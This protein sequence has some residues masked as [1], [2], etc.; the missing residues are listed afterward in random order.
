MSVTIDSLDIQIRSSAGSASANIDRLADSLGKLREN[1][2]LSVVANNLT[3]LSE[4]LG[5][6]QGSSSGLSSIKGL[7]GAMKSLSQ[8]EKSSGLNSTL[9]SLK[10]LP[11]IVNQ[12]DVG[13]LG[14]FSAKMR[15]LAAA[16]APLSTQLDKVSRSF[17]K[18]PAR[19]SQIVTGTNRMAKASR[20]AAEAQEEHNEAIDATSLNLATAISNLQNYIGALQAIKEKIAAFLADAI[21]WDGIQF[22]FGR[23]FGE[24]ADEV[25]D[26]V[27]E[28]GEVLKINTQQFMQY[29][30]MFGSL[31]SGFG[32]SQDKITD[33]SVGLTELSYDIWAAYNDRYKTYED[34]FEA[35]RSAITGEI[36]P[37]RNAGIALTEAS[38]QEYLDSIGMASVSIEK[39]TEDQKSEVRYAVMVNSAMSQGI[40]GTYAREMNTAEGAIRTLTQQTKTL[41]QAI[42]SLFIP[43]LQVA[44]PWITAFVELLTEAVYWVAGLLGVEIQKIT[45]DTATSGVSGLANG[46]EDAEKALGGAAD[47]AK[48]LKSYTMGFDELN[49]I[50]PGSDAASGGSG[51]GDDNGWGDGLDLDRLWDDSVLASVK[52]RVEAI[53]EKIR[54][55]F[56]WIKE[57]GEDVLDLVLTIGAG[58]AA[59]KITA[60]FAESVKN[61]MD[62]LKEPTVLGKINKIA[63]GLSLVVTGITLS[64]TGGFD[65]GYEGPT[66]MN[67]LKAALGS[68]LGLVGSLLLFGTGPAGWIVGIGIGLVATITG[69]VIGSNKA[70]VEAELDSRFGDIELDEN[71]LTLYVDKITAV[72]RE[73]T[74]DS[75]GKKITFDAALEMYVSEKNIAESIET[76]LVNVLRDIETYDFKIGLGIEVPKE[77]YEA[78]ISRLVETSQ[79][80]LDQHYLTYGIALSFM[81]GETGETLS[82]TLDAF[83]SEN[84]T[85]L[86]ELGE[87][88]KTTVSAAFVDGEW[89]PEKLEEAK[90]IQ[91]EIQEI[92]EYVSDVEFRAKLEGLTLDVSG[93]D[94]TKESFEDVMSEA[95]KVIQEKL[96]TLGEVKMSQLQ[97][98]VMDYDANIASG[99]PEREAKKIYDQTVAI[100][101]EQYREGSFEVE[102]GTFD[103]GIDT[104]TSAFS[105]AV[106]SAKSAGALDFTAHLNNA[107]SFEPGLLFNDGEGEIYGNIER[108]MSNMA[109]EFDYKATEIKPEV[110]KALASVLEALEPTA[111][112][113]E[114]LAAVSRDAGEAVPENLRKGLNDYNQ[115]K[116][117]SGDADAI[118]YMIGAAFSTDTAF[119]NTLATVE[120]AGRDIDESVAKGLLNNIEYVKDQA[121]GVVTGIKNTMTGEV[122]AITPEM[123]KNF[124]QLGVDISDGLLDGADKE[125]AAQKQSWLD[126]AIWP[127]N[128]FKEKNEINSPSKLF[129]RGGKYLGDGLLSG[130]GSSWKDIKEWYNTNVAPKLT[131]NFW[132]TKFTNIKNGFVQT[133]KNAVNAGID[134]MNRFIGWIN[135]KLNFSWDALTIA[136]KEVFPAGSIQLFTLPP[137]PRLEKGGF[138][139]DGLFTMNHGEIAGKFSNGQSVVANN[140]QIV[141]GIAAG[142]Y[143]AVV[144]AMNATNGRQDQNVNVY[145]DGRQ[146]TTV[147]E[148]RQSERGRSLMGNQLGYVY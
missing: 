2:K 3:K 48:K 146:I 59:W 30:S 71:M 131:L 143:E 118:N 21:E 85:K 101:E 61:L 97:V 25:Y 98:A 55:L 66:L 100:I 52:D 23:A 119:L 42:G 81:T 41:A 128:W 6:L 57:N 83:Y 45:W 7:A 20:D 121:T 39:L 126:W 4:A 140:Q 8:V 122:I 28:L 76:S 123:V 31:L 64:Y 111:Q 54:P 27:M 79:E 11:E 19:I 9:N 129:E 43:I 110:R 104:I 124:G 148:K 40:V 144:A 117:L 63:L 90:K 134:L 84:S 53:K 89:I 95:Q 125:M 106:E 127:W 88:L 142:V 136:G 67:I 16:L 5:K 91:K 77:A 137:I 115:L 14:A 70:K 46:A 138:L 130:I 44:I 58:F 82:E 60:N 108:L 74:V 24:D 73:L 49:V 37:I 15:E 35:V 114:K 103:F 96:D 56:D 102:F 62:K 32:M 139:E 133:I 109:L 29:S 78:A 135:D 105:D 22:R 13:T 132:V 80:Y 12:L 38:M 34:A 72:S 75:T 33:I 116:A 87:K 50:N 26:Y 141:E 51:T 68:A 113:Y 147:V 18:L 93:T 107:I 92:L 65:I 120:G 17:S 94:L 69:I 112:D 10:K 145:L 1:A 36:E 47:A 86:K 99:M